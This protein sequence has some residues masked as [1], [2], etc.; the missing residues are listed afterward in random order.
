M[1]DRGI[2]VSAF[3]DSGCSEKNWIHPSLVA[4]GGYIPMATDKVI[5]KDFQGELAVTQQAVS[6]EWNVAD[7]YKSQKTNFYIAKEKA[8]FQILFGRDFMDSERLFIPNPEV[9]IL[10]NGG[11][12]KKN[13]KLPLSHKRSGKSGEH[14]SEPA[15]IELGASPHQ[16]CVNPC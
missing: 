16:I 10:S 8:P 5:T 7:N 14:S 11:Q 1:D 13:P 3:L 4:Q 12:V 2:F 15:D 9:N 6:V